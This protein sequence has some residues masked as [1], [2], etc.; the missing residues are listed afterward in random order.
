MLRIPLFHNARN[1]DV[2][3]AEMKHLGMRLCSGM[4]ARGKFLCGVDGICGLYAH[5][6]V[7]PQVGSDVLE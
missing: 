2:F 5:E 6:T 1:A 4:L 3:K 7:T